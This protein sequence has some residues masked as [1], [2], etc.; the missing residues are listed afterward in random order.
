MTNYEIFSRC[1]PELG[2]NE[3]Q[4]ASLSGAAECRVFEADGGFAM[5]RD[6]KLRLLCVLPECQGHGI[7]GRLLAECEDYI[8][9]RG[10][11]T[12][13]IGGTDSGLFIGAVKSSAGFFEKHGYSFGGDI[14]E[15]CGESGEL[16]LNIQS[17][18]CVEFISEPGGSER[19]LN[20]VASVDRDWVQYFGEGDILCA[21]VSG[22][23]AA[24]CIVEDDV[25]C[26]FS[27]EG[28]RVGGIGCVGTVPQMR[29][30]GIGLA[31]VAEASRELIRRG[32]GRI[33]IHYTDVY[34]WYS[35]LGYKT[36]LWIRLG[37]KIV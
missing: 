16:S 7:G 31:M 35:R 22:E 24:F 36:R 20:A 26:I 6:N 19:L 25:T 18:S 4:F 17:P 27:D 32:C 21:S 5:V 13:E 2:L 8:R 33:F 10:Y 12:A 30:H 9:R 11:S 1:F 29:R 28:T 14:A 23:I 15:M 34:D 37:G 3:N